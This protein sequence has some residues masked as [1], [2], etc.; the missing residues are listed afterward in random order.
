MPDRANFGT[1]AKP[2]QAGHAASAGLRAALLAETG[3]TAAEDAIDGVAGFSALYSQGETLAA[4]LSALGNDVL[5]IETSGVE[6]KKYPA[7]Y[8]VHRPLDGILD[9]RRE[10]SL[11]PTDIE[12]I[13]VQAS[14]GSLAPLLDRNPT[15]ATEGRFS[16][17]YT[18]A[19]ALADGHVVLGSFTEQAV[20]RAELRPLMA[21]I[22]SSETPGAMNP[23]WAHLTVTLK[24]GRVLER[25][26]DAARIC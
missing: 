16:M 19:A 8:N 9:L 4:E 5:E 11:Q 21:R 6:I 13:D 3:F 26:I 24:D 23:R 10:H 17:A 20:N 14:Q 22:H 1:D 25:R 12:R 18:V 2:F 15:T 7:C